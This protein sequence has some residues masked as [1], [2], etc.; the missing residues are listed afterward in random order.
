LLALGLDFVSEDF[1][2]RGIYKENEGTRSDENS[3]ENEK[4]QTRGNKP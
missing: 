2:K 1:E 3:T 4:K